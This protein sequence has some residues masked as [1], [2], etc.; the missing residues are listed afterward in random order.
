M[1]PPPGSLRRTRRTLVAICAH[2]DDE[3]LLIGGTLATAAAAGHRVVVVMATGGER[4]LSALRD[5]SLGDTRAVE[6]DRAAALLGVSDVIKLDFADSGFRSPS[7]PMAGSLVAS[8]VAAVENAL[9]DVVE[10]LRPDSVI[11]HDERG[12]YGHRDHVMCH[13]AGLAACRRAG[14]P[15]VLEATLPRERLVAALRVANALRV[16]PGG[17]RAADCT[18]WYTPT[19]D[20]THAIDVRP[21]LAAKRQAIA[22]HVSQLAGGLDQRT[23]AT[24]TRLPPLV[25]RYVLGTE[26]FVEPGRS[27]HRPW[28]RDVF[29]SLP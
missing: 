14:V 15:V 17:V 20:I 25:A 2:P 1:T 9:Y 7:L 19:R 27:P 11:L 10:P 18:A 13:R 3:T 8:G 29:A 22:A 26:W 24:L 21:Q 5:E 6:L 16:Q 4:G 23:L 28:E 12:G